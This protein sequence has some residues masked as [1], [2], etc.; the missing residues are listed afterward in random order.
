MNLSW[1]TENRRA[2]AFLWG[3]LVALS[4]MRVWSSLF[5]TPIYL[6][7]VLALFDR[8]TR[9]GLWQLAGRL[10]LTLGYFAL[11]ACSLLWAASPHLVLQA[12]RADIL[13]PCLAFVASFHAARRLDAQ[14]TA[15]A[16]LL[17]AWC[18]FLLGG[19]IGYLVLG[20]GWS[21]RLFDSVGYYSSYVFMLAGASLPFL[22]RNRRLLFYPLVAVLLFLSQ[23][24]V[25]WVVFP[26][27]GLADILLCRR[28]GASLKGLFVFGLLIVVASIGMLKW[29]AEQKPVDGLNPGVQA[30]SLLDR[31]AK[32]ERLRPWREWF[33]RGLESPIIG[34]GFGRDN[35]KEHFARGADWPERNLNHGHNILINNFLQLGALG[36]AAYL[37]AQFQLGRFLFRQRE[38]LAYAALCILG[39]FFLRNLFDDFSFKRLLIVYALLL[40][41]SIGGLGK[42][43]TSPNTTD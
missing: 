5:F 15:E 13:I 19:A 22:T 27:I 30:S 35:V 23:Q 43:S 2:L 34:H 17:G 14:R 21:E 29:V 33:E 3:G 37:M 11:A 32:N 41:W 28:Q 7:T 36:V 25:A 38:P 6:M 20:S 40:G 42:R 39:L 1:I 31:L 26:F 16:L 10:P 24:R 12:L 8:E 9:D 4:M 18:C